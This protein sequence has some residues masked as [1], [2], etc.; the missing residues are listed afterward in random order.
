MLNR[1]LLADAKPNIVHM[2]PLQ[3]TED[4]TIEKPLNSISIAQIAIIKRNRIAKMQKFEETSNCGV[5]FNAIS[6]AFSSIQTDMN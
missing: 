6:V 4:R 1:L 3:M 5:R 2:E